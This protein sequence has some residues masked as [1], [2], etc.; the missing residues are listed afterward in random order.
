M[1]IYKRSSLTSCHFIEKQWD[2]SIGSSQSISMQIVNH[3]HSA[4]VRQNMTGEH[5]NWN[6]LIER[7]KEYRHRL[8]QGKFQLEIGK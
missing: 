1:L 8:E 7:T 6:A 2:S 5:R 3:H 4:T